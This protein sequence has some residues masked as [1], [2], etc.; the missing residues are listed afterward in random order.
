MRNTAR[1]ALAVVLIAGTGILLQARGRNEV[2]P[3]R[4]PLESFPERVGAWSATDIPLDN[5]VLSVLGQG[6]FLL[7]EYS[8]AGDAT[9]V[10]NLFIAYFP[11]QRAGD[12]IHSPQHC[13]PGA[14]WRPVENARSTLSLPGHEPFPVNRYVVSKQDA[15]QLVLYWFW[16]HD[17]GVAS[18]YWAKFYLI[19]DAME[20]NRSDGA[21]VRITTAM[22]PGES[23]EAA[24]RRLLPF[25]AD[26]LPLLNTYIPR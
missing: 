18:E 11:S 12:T 9:P 19:K 22:Y 13:L 17:R 26:L 6:D 4:K 14:G 7:R 25:T 10:I 24:E 21:L 1:F 5:D 2:F 23:S 15:R 16:A 3:P 20:L 8:A